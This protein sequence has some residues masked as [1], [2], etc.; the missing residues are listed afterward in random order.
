M[1]SG[2][3][4]RDLD[5][6]WC[7]TH[8]N[9]SIHPSSIS[10]LFPRCLPP[11]VRL[12]EVPRPLLE[13][14][15]T[16]GRRSQGPGGR[17]TFGRRDDGHCA[18][19]RCRAVTSREGRWNGQWGGL[20]MGVSKNNGTPKSSILIGFSIINHPFWWFSPYFWKYPNPWVPS[21]RI[22]P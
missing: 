13:M 7:K 8:R 11:L 16:P 4:K 22:L 20:E 14:C 5:F 1:I 2:Q 3:K 17:G 15:V 12:I 6:F 21:T 19:V 18:M 9:P 10:L